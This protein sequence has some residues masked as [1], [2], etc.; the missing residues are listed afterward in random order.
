MKQSL[1]Y[2]FSTQDAWLVVA[3]E[4]LLNGG[5]VIVKI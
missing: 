5:F 1:V 3:F 4:I 2:S